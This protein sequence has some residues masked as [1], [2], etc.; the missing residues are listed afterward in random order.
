MRLQDL[1]NHLMT[2]RS[3]SLTGRGVRRPDHV[4]DDV[5]LGVALVCSELPASETESIVR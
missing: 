1:P 3:K 2:S 4:R 5:T